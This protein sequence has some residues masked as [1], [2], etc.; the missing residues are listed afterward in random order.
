MSILWAGI[1]TLIVYKLAREVIVLK[2]ESAEIYADY[3]ISRIRASVRAE[4]TT[5]QLAEIRRVLVA[6]DS[7]TRHG[8]DFRLHLPLYFRG[9]YF[10]LLAGRDRRRSTLAA[11]L[12]RLRRLP[13]WL[14][15]GFV[16]A[17]SAILILTLMSLVL[18]ALYLVKS[19]AGLDIFTD[20]HLS[21]LIS[22]DIYGWAK[23]S[24]G[25][26]E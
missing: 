1:G 10:V 26:V 9:Y 12:V 4:L 21:D 20:L 5:E 14:R 8:I 18:I 25:R 7:E 16:F 3:T 23:D 17:V 19:F 6:M 22:M 2:R 24:I 15:R 13:R 11:E